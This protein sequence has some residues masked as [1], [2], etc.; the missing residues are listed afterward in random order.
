M[1]TNNDVTWAAIQSLKTNWGVKDYSTLYNMLS[2]EQKRVF[3]KKM[4]GTKRVVANTATVVPAKPEPEL[5]ESEKEKIRSDM[6]LAKYKDN[7]EPEV[8]KSRLDSDKKKQY[9]DELLADRT[10]I[11]GTAP[12]RNC[13]NSCYFNAELQLLFSIPEFRDTF[14]NVIGDWQV[15]K[16]GNSLNPLLARIILKD[17][18]NIFVSMYRYSL[19]GI[20]LNPQTIVGSQGPDKKNAR[21]MRAFE[22]LLYVM[23]LIK[24]RQYDAGEFLA[25]FIAKLFS[26]CFLLPLKR[27]FSIYYESRI[28]CVNELIKPKP[29][30]DYSNLLMLSIEDSSITDIQ[31]AINFYQTQ[32]MYSD[33]DN[34]LEGCAVPPERTGLGAYR[35]IKIIVPDETKYILIN[36]VRNRYTRAGPEKIFKAI[37]LNSEIQIAGNRFKLRMCVTHLGQS[38]DSGHYVAY[39]FDDTGAPVVR[40]D[41]ARIYQVRGEDSMFDFGDYPTHNEKIL[42]GALTVLYER[43]GPVAEFEGFKPFKKEAALLRLGR[44]ELQEDVACLYDMTESEL[45]DALAGRPSGAANAAARFQLSTLAARGN[46]SRLA[47][48]AAAAAAERAAGAPAGGRRTRKQKKSSRKTRRKH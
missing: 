25:Q 48:E 4:P 39:K 40:F 44:G 16:V 43:I 1:A 22:E 29:K 12:L 21:K 45:I 3:L 41:D 5:K 31:T 17:F 34:E 11:P 18:N 14:K 19:I 26:F 28:H 20:P 15:K 42:R 27:K 6:V 36:V 13:G 38:T 37:N 2:N 32:E 46:V 24:G 8:F 9:V 23:E 10:L 30:V 33:T 7:T 35:Q 47:R